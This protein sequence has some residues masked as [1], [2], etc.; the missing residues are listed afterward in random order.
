MRSED[1][2][3]WANAVVARRHRIGR[4]DPPDR[5]IE[6][7]KAPG[8]IFPSGDRGRAPLP[9]PKFKSFNFTPILNVI[10]NVNDSLTLPSGNYLAFS[11]TVPLRKAMKF[12]CFIAP[13][14]VIATCS[15]PLS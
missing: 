8:N 1:G 6:I 3:S 5:P 11:V 2:F 7:L 4:A 13:I 12:P 14:T 9:G 10:E 15:P